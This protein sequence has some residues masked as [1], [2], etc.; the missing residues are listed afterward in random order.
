M[1]DETTGTLFCGDL[2][3]MFGAYAP[4]TTDDPAPAAAALER[5]DGYSSW[6]RVPNSGEQVRRLADLGVTTLAPM[7][8]AAYSGDATATLTALA[9]DLDAFIAGTT[10]V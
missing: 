2:F 1:F 4:T 10:R 3:T 6:S 5:A 8:W 9:D 7:H